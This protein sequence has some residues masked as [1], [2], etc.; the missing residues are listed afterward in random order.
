MKHLP[1]L[2][3]LVCFY[4]T[5]YAQEQMQ[6]KQV[7]M[8]ASDSLLNAVF[9][10]LEIEYERVEGKENIYKLAL[11]GHTVLAGID[12]GNLALYTIYSDQPS[13]NRINDF[14][15][16]YRWSRVYLDDDGDLVIA[17]ELDFE[18]GIGIGNIYAFINTYGKLVDALVEHMK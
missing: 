12:N 13:L 5:L 3:L 2:F 9:G 1:L 4:N 8:F 18:G 15:A 16:Q 6:Q 11:N 14:N 10:E 17:D 7:V